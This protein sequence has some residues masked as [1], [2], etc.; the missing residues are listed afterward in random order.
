[1]TEPVALITGAGSGIGR[2]VAVALA[3][4]GWAVA[5]LDCREQGLETLATE[6]QGQSRRCAWRVADVTQADALRDRISDLELE[7][8]ATDLLIAS[9]GVGIETSAE[10]LR[11]AD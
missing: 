8:G 3:R 4:R 10:N 6:L 11:P 2:A 1:M 7:L 5:A 9:A